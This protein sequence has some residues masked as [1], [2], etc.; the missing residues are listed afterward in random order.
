[1]TA[2]K[3]EIQNLHAVHAVQLSLYL[4]IETAYHT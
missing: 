1:M 4:D 3:Y 2:F